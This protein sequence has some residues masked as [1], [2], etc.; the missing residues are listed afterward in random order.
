MNE[1]K[2][3]ELIQ[4]AVQNPYNVRFNDLAK[5]CEHYFGKARQNGTNHRIYKT[6]WV[7]D[8]RI[9]IQEGENGKAKVYQVKQVLAAIQK[10]K[11]INHG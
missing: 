11:E 7:G 1:N 3:E 4:N 9:N 8:P 2:I 6:P 10:L 5:L